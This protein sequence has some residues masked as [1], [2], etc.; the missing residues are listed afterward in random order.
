MQKSLKERMNK[1]ELTIGSWITLSHPSIA[2]I[3]AKCGFDW[4]AIDMEHSAITIAEAQILICIIESAGIVPLVRVG[5]NDPYL[6]KR[7]M[8]AGAHGV[9]VP[10]VNSMEDAEKAV[11]AIKYPPQGT[12]GV[13]LTRAQNYSMDFETYRKWNQKNSVLIVLIENI[14]GVENLESIMSVKGVDAFIVGPYDLSGSLG[15]PGEFNNPKVKEALKKIYKTS[16]KNNYLMGQHIVAPDPKIVN[17]KIKEGYRLIGFGTDFLF[18]NV[19]CQKTLA[20]I[21]RSV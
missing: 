13:G 4:L 11:A 6:I 18:L 20:E 19:F 21:K 17:S 7:V 2:E 9:I 5:N 3:L 1:R 12:R 15:C 8:D 14:K 16:K 10:Q